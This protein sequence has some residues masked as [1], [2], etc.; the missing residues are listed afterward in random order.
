[1]QIKIFRRLFMVTLALI[2]IL[3]TL[4]PLTPVFAAGTPPTTISPPMNFAASNFEG[5]Y[6]ECTLSA[7][8]DLRALMD[9][10]TEQRGYNLGV[11]GQVDFKVDN[12]NWHYTAAWD[13]PNTYKNYTLLYSNA[14]NGG[15]FGEYLG[16]QDLTY[17]NMFPDDENL[18]VTGGNSWEWFKSH[19]VTFRARFSLDVGGGKL[20]FSDWSDEY[21][22]SDSNK[23]DY[24]KIL[25]ANP[26]VLKSSKIE[27]Q[28]NTQRPYLVLQLDRHPAEIQKLNAMMGNRS[29]T[30][31][32]LRMKDDKEFKKVDAHF[33]NREILMV[34]VQDYF[35]NTQQSYDAAAYEIKIRYCVD[36]QNYAH[37]GVKN[38]NLLYTP[39]SNTLSYNMPAWSEASTWASGEL[40]KAS[41]L[42]LIPDSLKGADMT[43][44]I[45]RDEFAEVALLMYEKASGIADTAPISPNPFKDTTNPRILKAF[46]LGIVKGVSTTEFAPDALI[47]REQVSAMLTRTIKL[48]APDAD[49][50]TTGAPAFSDQKDISGWALNDCLF[51]AKIGIIKGSDGKFMPRA[52]S[53]AQKAIGYANTSREQAL[54]MSVRTVEKIKEIK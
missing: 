13:D 8:E 42:G 19:K 27:K 14:F 9:Q 35:G 6:A 39:Y 29:R 10:T 16:R 23:V 30:E 49:Y 33:F 38:Q 15:T 28:E 54:A 3:M 45:T 5:Y 25:A 37:S 50:S 12:G 18:P 44:N 21:V 47:N 41:D 40:Q 34:N 4:L 32:W 53:D 48:I 24:K 22:L 7:P 1:M 20:L 46:K 52:V 31:I 17:K 36:E 51:M 43:K 11:L 2:L 26:P